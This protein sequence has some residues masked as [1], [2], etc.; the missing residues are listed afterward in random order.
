[1]D[2]LAQDGNTLYGV[3]RRPP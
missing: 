3:A 1:M 2:G